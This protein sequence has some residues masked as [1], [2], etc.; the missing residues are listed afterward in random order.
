[1]GCAF[2]TIDTQGAI[3]VKGENMLQLKVTDKAPALALK[4]KPIFNISSQ[5]E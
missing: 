5:Q 2:N 3:R 4:Y 1:M